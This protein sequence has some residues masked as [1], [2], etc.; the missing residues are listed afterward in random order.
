MLLPLP[1]WPFF[2]YIYFICVEMLV[3]FNIAVKKKIYSPTGRMTH[4]CHGNRCPWAAEQKRGNGAPVWRLRVP[5][6]FNGHHSLAPSLTPREKTTALERCTMRAIVKTSLKDTWTPGMEWK[7][8]QVKHR[9]RSDES[10]LNVIKTGQ[11]WSKTNLTGI[12][13]FSCLQGLFTACM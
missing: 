9:C 8:P 10:K 3:I 11:T 12:W 1:I 7:G 5:L 4:R 2:G 13:V 6:Q